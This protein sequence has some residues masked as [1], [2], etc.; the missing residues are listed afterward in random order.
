MR[1]GELYPRFARKRRIVFPSWIHRCSDISSST[2]EIFLSSLFF[3]PCLSICFYFILPLSLS[4]S[5]LPLISFRW[6]VTVAFVVTPRSDRARTNVLIGAGLGWG[7]PRVITGVSLWTHK[8]ARMEVD[9]IVYHASVVYRCTSRGRLNRPLVVGLREEE[10]SSKRSFHL[11]LQQQFLQACNC[12][13]W[14][15]F[16][17]FF[18]P[19]RFLLFPIFGP[20]S[21]SRIFLPHFE[22]RSF[23]FLFFFFSSQTIVF[24]YL[25]EMEYLSLE[26]VRFMKN[27]LIKRR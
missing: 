22:H 12:K 6:P 4:L 13:H 19:T 5:L 20:V 15:L 17:G 9:S 18:L 3:H 8:V 16:S 26:A 23:D 14:T 1:I 25:S 24:R 11:L 21:I 27:V 10:E 7:I 2:H